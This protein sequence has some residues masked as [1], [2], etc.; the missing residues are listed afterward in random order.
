MANLRFCDKLIA[1]RGKFALYVPSHTI[2]IYYS[3][4]T[5]VSAVTWLIPMRWGSWCRIMVVFSVKLSLEIM[6]GDCAHSQTQLAA[7]RR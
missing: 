2:V 1:I 4:I 3:R 6:H 5:R 7:T